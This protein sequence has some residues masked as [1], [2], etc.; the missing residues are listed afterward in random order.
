[1]IYILSILISVGA[2]VYGI[3]LILDAYKETDENKKSGYL[4]DAGLLIFSAIF[5]LLMSIY[6]IYGDIQLNR[7]SR[8]R[9]RYERC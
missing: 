8:D 9:M 3:F 7:I 2:L 5:V 1:M 6:T 4:T